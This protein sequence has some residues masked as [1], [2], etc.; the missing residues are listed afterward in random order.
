M[1]LGYW[2]CPLIEL[3][4]LKKTIGRSAKGHEVTYEG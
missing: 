1:V 2:N 4:R 3:G